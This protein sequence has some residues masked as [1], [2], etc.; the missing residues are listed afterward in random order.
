MVLILAVVDGE[1]A[2]AARAHIRVRLPPIQNNRFID[3][4]QGKE[5]A[6]FGLPGTPFVNMNA[7]N[8]GLPIQSIGFRPIG[9]YP[10]SCTGNRF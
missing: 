4:P 3:F 5:S 6:V 9:L 10:F 7:W 8:H 2:N 1:A